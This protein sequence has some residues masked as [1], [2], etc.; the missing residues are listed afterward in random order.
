[1]QRIICN[2]RSEE[3]KYTAKLLSL[4]PNS[5][6]ERNTPSLKKNIKKMP[7]QL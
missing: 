7:D 2:L 3:N 4:T 1:M 6:V 5:R